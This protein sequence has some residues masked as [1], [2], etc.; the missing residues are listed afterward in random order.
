VFQFF[1]LNKVNKTSSFTAI[2]ILHTSLQAVNP[3]HGVSTPE[4]TRVSRRGN[5]EDLAVHNP[6]YDNRRRR[7][8]DDGEVGGEQAVYLTP[9]SATYDNSR[10]SNDNTS[11]RAPHDNADRNQ[12]GLDADKHTYEQIRESQMQPSSNDTGASGRDASRLVNSAPYQLAGVRIT[13]SGHI[14]HERNTRHRVVSQLSEQGELASPTH[15]DTES[16]H[17]SWS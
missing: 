7:D 1:K 17:K 14:P 6:D 2:S 16:S 3:L 10:G 5:G 11:R 13:E 15:H 8:D 9:I 4:I 12:G